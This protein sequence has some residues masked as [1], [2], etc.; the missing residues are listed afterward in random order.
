MLS[1]LKL[2]I[3][4]FSLAISCNAYGGALLHGGNTPG[5]IE[6]TGT[7]NSVDQFTVV[8]IDTSGNMAGVNNLS[9]NSISGL[10]SLNASGAL[11]SGSVS[12]GGITSG[13]VSSST[14]ST[15]G[16]ATLNST[17]VT[18]SAT[19]GGTL[20]V[21]GISTLG[22]LNQTG[23]T[24]INTTG[25]AT[26]TI[27]SA[28]AGD[29]LL[30]SATG[31]TLTVQ[32]SGTALVGTTNTI[33]GATSN[34]IGT[35][36]GGTFV[37][38]TTGLT[39]LSDGHGLTVDSANN[40]TTL[41][42]G[43]NSSTLTLQDRSATLS[44]GTETTAEIDVIR[45]TNN[46][47][48]T[49]VVIGGA[50]NSSA[51]IVSGSNSLSTFSTAQTIGTDYTL[52]NGDAN[53]QSLLIDK[54][55][56][57]IIVGDTVVDGDMY[58]NGS[59][60]FASNTS[61]KITVGGGVSSLE[62]ATSL[63][64]GTVGIA[65]NNGAAVDGNG[66]IFAAGATAPTASLTLTNGYG[67]THGIV[68]TETQTTISGGERSSS[69]TLNDNGA[70]FTNAQTGGPIQVHG[71]ADG[72][73]DFDAV[74]IRQFGSAISSVSAMANIPEVA[75]D[76]T[77]S[78]GLG[79]GNYMNYKSLAL[80]GRFRFSRNVVLKTS[81]AKNTRGIGHTTIGLGAAWSW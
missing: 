44:V 19:V 72:T 57:N 51:Q 58:I 63:T 16:L 48:A 2:S 26:T 12:T 3:S 1:R 17:S 22:A 6:T 13:N 8:T 70:T 35:T 76:K 14:L 43:T 80:G 74:N 42:G 9:V 52:I 38:D 64:S 62:D 67:N 34:T 65:N 28:S 50:S 25:V 61:S 54:T 49:S 68:V 71:I 15:S 73:G 31:S 10:S 45:A 66:K 46:G 20:G 69:M 41:T 29:I 23:I 32:D 27:G 40:I 77:F 18:N 55:V 47:T 5:R 56:N 30:Q 21:T 36:G 24:N 79:Y 39:A 37:T 53:S 11:T 4:F 60:E 33:S 59:L 75:V 81:L 78:L 7:D